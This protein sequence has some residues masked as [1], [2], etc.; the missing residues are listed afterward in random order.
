MSFIG[1]VGYAMGNFG[2][3]EVLNQVCAENSG[4]YMLSGKA[5]VRAVRG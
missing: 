5:Y 2:L 3:E 1:S 4:L